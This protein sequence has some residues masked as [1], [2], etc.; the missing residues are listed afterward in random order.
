MFCTKSWHKSPYLKWTCEIPWSARELSSFLPWA[1]AGSVELQCLSLCLGPFKFNVTSFH[2]EERI[3]V[4]SISLEMKGDSSWA[5]SLSL[6]ILPTLEIRSCAFSDWRYVL[7]KIFEQYLGSRGIFFSFFNTRK[8]YLA[9]NPLL[10]SL[11]DVR[12]RDAVS[13]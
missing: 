10:E 9:I 13:F 7:K 6:S 1:L 12:R 4:A 3:E 11:W 2:S 5:C 8:S